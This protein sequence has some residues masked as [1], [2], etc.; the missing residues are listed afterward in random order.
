MTGT[1]I[2][3]HTHKPTRTHG[4][5]V[6]SMRYTHDHADFDKAGHCIDSG[7]YNLTPQQNGK[8]LHRLRFH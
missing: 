1:L 8:H 6:K 4:L 5:R 7:E 3:N 2:Y